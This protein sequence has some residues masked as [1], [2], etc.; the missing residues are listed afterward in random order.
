MQ[1]PKES[2][3]A[4]VSSH[5][6]PMNE[7]PWAISDHYDGKRFHNPQPRSQGFGSFL[8]WMATRNQGGWSSRGTN[9][10]APAPP[11]RVDD[12][13]VT[14][15]GHTTVL[16]QLNGINVLTDPVWS[17]RASPS[18]LIGPRRRSNPGIVY[19]DLPHID[20]VLISHDH[21]DHMDV[22]TLRR[23]ERDHHPT[24]LTG[25]GN[26]ARLA[27]FGIAEAIERDWWDAQQLFRDFTVTPVPAKHFSGRNLV[28]RDT[29]L[30]CGFVLS[31]PAGHVY[32]AGD[33]G[34]GPHYR[35]IAS[36]FR[37]IRTALLP[38]G[39]YR[40]EWFM[41]EVHQTPL[42]AFQAHRELAARISIATHW[43]TFPL[44]DDGQ[45]EPADALRD[46]LSHSDLAGTNFWI[47]DFGEGREIPTI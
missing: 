6:H 15:I 10:P 30:W 41:G 46:I 42:E 4:L 24:F 11:A 36:R 18:S 27:S 16:I 20:V 7:R 26:A 22:T 25:L 35:E 1:R 12:L 43:G 33:T 3:L 37:P 23:L 34:F 47:F 5:V 13:R 19:E 21:Y 17:E 8:R 28:D 29:T 31:A 2:S 45:F 39:A 32:F 38:I 9:S 44:G 14:W 40:P